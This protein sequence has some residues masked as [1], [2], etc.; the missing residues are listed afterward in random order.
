MWRKCTPNVWYLHG[1]YFKIGYTFYLLWYSAERHLVL[2]WVSLYFY[3]NVSFRES[4]VA[5]LVLPN[6]NKRTSIINSLNKRFPLRPR[7]L[8]W[9]REAL[10]YS[11]NLVPFIKALHVSIK[12]T[13]PL[14]EHPPSHPSHP[15]Q[16][17]P[18]SH[19]RV[20]TWRIQCLCVGVRKRGVSNE[21][22]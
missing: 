8:R 19:T 18:T 9:E 14:T 6:M 12:W 3:R 17:P 16:Q 15:Y 4:W 2:K 22:L 5:V 1:V 10:L 21:L 20:I 7:G 13:Q 11:T